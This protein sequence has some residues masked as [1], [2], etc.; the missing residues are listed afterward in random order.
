[1]NKETISICLPIY[2]CIMALSIQHTASKQAKTE[3]AIIICVSHKLTSKRAKQQLYRFEQHNL[4]C[5]D[6]Y[7]YIQIENICSF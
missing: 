3:W 5:S 7:M 4:K 1:M 2:L 6:T